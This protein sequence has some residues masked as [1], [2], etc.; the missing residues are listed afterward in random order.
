[1]KY[2]ISVLALAAVVCVPAQASAQ[3]IAGGYYM[4]IPPTPPPVTY[5]SRY[6]PPGAY[7]APGTYVYQSSPAPRAY[8]VRPAGDGNR[9]G[10]GWHGGWGQRSHW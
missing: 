8:P 9:Q 7:G 4:P 6:A 3:A 5:Q 10:G 1:M 2:G